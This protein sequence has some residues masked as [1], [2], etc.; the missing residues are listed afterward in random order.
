MDAAPSLDDA[1]LGN[2]SQAQIG[3]T[4]CG[5]L[6]VSVI[7]LEK[8][9]STRFAVAVKKPGIYTLTLVL[10][11]TDEND[12]S[13]LPISVFQDRNLL[14]TFTLTG[15]EREWKPLEMEVKAFSGNFY[16]RFFAAQTGL[17]LQSCRLELKEALGR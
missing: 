13:Q 3:E 10:R 1:D 5:E 12:V 14:G 6:D 2:L 15:S 9:Q 4:G 8:G 16:L 17:A 11:S 7:G